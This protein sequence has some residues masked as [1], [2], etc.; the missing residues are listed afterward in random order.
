MYDNR[1]DILYLIFKED[2]AHDTV[3][4]CEDVYVEFNERGEVIGIE[5][6][7]AS[8]LIIRPIVSEI[9]KEIQSFLVKVNKINK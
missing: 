7:R 8:E 1:H 2:H 5:I 9:A 3:E 4:V 6:W